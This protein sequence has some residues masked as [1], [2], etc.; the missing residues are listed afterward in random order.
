MPTPGF[1][2][3]RSYNPPSP[4]QPVIP[5]GKYSPTSTTNVKADYYMPPVVGQDQRVLHINKSGQAIVDMEHLAGS[6]PNMGA[7]M[8]FPT[9]AEITIQL[10]FLPS[11]VTPSHGIDSNIYNQNSGYGSGQLGLENAMEDFYIKVVEAGLGT[12]VDY[13]PTGYKFPYRY[14]TA[15]VASDVTVTRLAGARATIDLIFN[16]P[17]GLWTYSDGTTRIHIR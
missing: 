11:W 6:Y 2:V 9:S 16:V 4:G 3:F 8:A 17:S 15:V 7:G 10:D 1:Y 14:T 5:V 12:L 13:L